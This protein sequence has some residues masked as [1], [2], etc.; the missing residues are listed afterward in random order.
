MMM[1]SKYLPLVL[2]VLSAV[3]VG[4]TAAQDSGGVQTVTTADGSVG[5]IDWS[6]AGSIQVSG[7]GVGSSEAAARRAAIVDGQRLLL[8]IIQG[9]QLVAGVSAGDAM[10]A[11]DIVRTRVRGVLVGA[12]PLED[13]ADWDGKTYKIT[14]ALPLG[15]LRQEIT[16]VLI[17]DIDLPVPPIAFDDR[18]SI[19]TGETAALNV[20]ANDLDR[21]GDPLNATLVSGVNYGTLTLNPDGNVSYVHDGGDATS[22]AFVYR[23]SDAASNSGNATVTIL[24]AANAAAGQNEDPE[25]APA[26]TSTLL[27]QAHRLTLEALENEPVRSPDQILWREM[28]ALVDEAVALSPTAPA[29]LRAR[30]RAYGYVHWHAR[31]WEYWRDYLGSGGTLTDPAGLTPLELTSEELFIEAGTELG[32][33]RYRSDLAA[34]ALEIYLAVL[35]QLPDQ[36]QALREA[37][38]IHLEADRLEEAL[39]YFGRLAELRPDDA[40]VLLIASRIHLEAGR[41][42]ETVRILGRLAVLE[43]DAALELYLAVLELLPDD[44]ESLRVEALTGAGRLHLEADRLLEALPYFEQLAELRPDDA[45]IVG[46]LDN[47]RDLVGTRGADDSPIVGQEG[48]TPPPAAEADVGGNIMAPLPPPT[49]TPNPRLVESIGPRTGIILDASRFWLHRALF[50]DVHDETSR[51]LRKA[52]PFNFHFDTLDSARLRTEDV[53]SNPEIFEVAGIDAN[54]TVILNDREAQRFLQLLQQQDLI[55]SGHALIVGRE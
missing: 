8:E 17:E 42:E 55:E 22:D 49:I 25:P 50:V 12:I 48:E 26:E 5:A 11:S 37:G 29:A 31:A 15:S 28:L 16:P 43:P 21:N 45:E 38:R 7:V 34:E 35:E 44:A 1:A 6:T 53:G 9:V 24:I 27:E 19:G 4:S 33:S 10:E 52:V 2:L 18:V 54:G 14:M 39:P 40:E 32:F 30:A 20:L 46:A 41:L 23:A 3:L 47:I 13:T 51:P 36:Q